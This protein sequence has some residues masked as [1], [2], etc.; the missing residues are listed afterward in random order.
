MALGMADVSMPMLQILVETAYQRR[1]V[2]E[3]ARD[4]AGAYVSSGSGWRQKT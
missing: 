3:R 2:Y 1:I 4:E